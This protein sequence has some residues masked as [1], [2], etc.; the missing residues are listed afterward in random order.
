MP[1]GR[2]SKKAKSNE[3]LRGGVPF[4]PNHVLPAEA[5]MGFGNGFGFAART[6]GHQAQQ[7]CAPFISAAL[8]PGMFVRRGKNE[9]LGHEEF[10]AA[11]LE[12]LVAVADKLE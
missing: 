1:A 2:A 11:L 3:H 12:G 10:G 6:P 8:V 9:A 5:R 7:C 4:A